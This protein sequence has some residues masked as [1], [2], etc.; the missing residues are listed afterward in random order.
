MVQG[1]S[2]NYSH[3]DI[4]MELLECIIFKTGR[5]KVRFGYV[6]KGSG[7]LG[8]FWYLAWNYN[9]NF[10]CMTT[11]NNFIWMK[12]ACI[13]SFFLWLL[14]FLHELFFAYF[15]IAFKIYSFL[16]LFLFFS[17]FLSQRKKFW[18]WIFFYI[19]TYNHIRYAQIYSHTYKSIP[20]LILTARTKTKYELCVRKNIIYIQIDSIY[21]III[22]KYIRGLGILYWKIA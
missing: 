11:S 21:D 8:Y 17:C 13:N 4:Q 16:H 6:V 2:K 18:C 7:D 15:W 9:F 1:I 3:I 20:Q 12:I 19:N 14:Y 10:F 22:T 5:F